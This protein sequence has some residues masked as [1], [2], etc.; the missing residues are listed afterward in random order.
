M[1]YKEAIPTWALCALINDDFS[2][3][4]DEDEQTI[5]HWLEVSGYSHIC[6][7][8][9]DEE[10]YFTGVPA[11]GLACDVIDCYCCYPD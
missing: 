7:P 10:S 3:L 4:E 2:G 8:D 6:P 1:Y 5:R 9:D 11:F